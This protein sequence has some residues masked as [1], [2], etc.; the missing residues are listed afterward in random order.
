ML[1]NVVENSNFSKHSPLAHLSEPAE[2]EWEIMVSSVVGFDSPIVFY[3]PFC[4]S[5]FFFFF[6]LFRE[7]TPS[8]P[9]TP[10]Q[11]GRTEEESEKKAAAVFFFWIE[12]F[13]NPAVSQI[14]LNEIHVFHVFFCV[15]CVHL[16]NKQFIIFC[17]RKNSTTMCKHC[18]KNNHICCSICMLNFT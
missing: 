14:S 16:L 7:S 4:F 18:S 8:R 11:G 12:M 17:V 10:P 6:G 2:I 1:G 13:L 5:S 3:S 15:R 9:T